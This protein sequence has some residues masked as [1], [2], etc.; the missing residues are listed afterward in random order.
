E[1][2]IAAWSAIHEGYRSILQDDDLSTRLSQGWESRKAD[3]IRAKAAAA[4]EEILVATE[5]D[6]NVGFATFDMDPAAGIGEIGNNAVSPE[7]Q[8]RGIGKQLHQRVLDIFREQGL[9]YALVTTGY[10]DAGH[11]SA[12]ASYEKVGF[13]KVK[14]SVTYGLRLG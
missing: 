3:Q 12:R 9:V 1:I 5:G 13:K 2:A 11:Q 14:T 10:E 6:R 8:G 7:F 4:P